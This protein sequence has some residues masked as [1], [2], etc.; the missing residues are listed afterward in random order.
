MTTLT[1]RTRI[2]ATTKSVPS[3][4]SVVLKLRKYLNDPDVSFD[5]LAK[6]IQYDPGL[7]A[8][9]LQLANSAYFGWAGTIKSVQGAITRL[10]T[11]RIFQMVLCMS[12]APL[13]SK[14][15]KGYDMDAGSLWEHSIATAVCA[16]QLALALKLEGAEDAFTAG[17]L[18]DIGKVVLGTFVDVDDE[19]IR[20][21]VNSDNLAF[22][23]AEM[24]VLGVDHGEVAA[25]LLENWQLPAEVIETAKFHHTPSKASPEHQQMVDLIHVADMLCLNVGW[26]QGTDG[27]QYKLDERA[28]DR[29][30]VRIGLAEEVVLKVMSGMEDL[31]D[32][33]K[34]STEGKPNGV[35]HTTR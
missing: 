23:E 31:K 8:N 12:V 1:E 25:V 21:I 20:E 6:V 10:G 26:G 17:L 4:P 22:N 15:I 33:Y 34:L 19:P 5:E 16:E 24:M 32:M 7:T 29:L 18:H 27:L 35:Q 2:L 28:N 11:N 30:G 14:P 3:L 9:V 13:V